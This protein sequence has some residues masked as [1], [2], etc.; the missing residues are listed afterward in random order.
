VTCTGSGGAT[1]N[2]PE[3]GDSTV[4]AIALMFHPAEKEQITNTDIECLINQVND[5]WD[6]FY[7]YSLLTLILKHKIIQN[8]GRK[9]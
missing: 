8:K 5:P 6:T 3:A 1:P 4:A 7:M 9:K 2:Q